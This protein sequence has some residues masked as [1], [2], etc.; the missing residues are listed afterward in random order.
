MSD[1]IYDF[2][3]HPQQQRGGLMVY[4]AAWRPFG[5][6]PP[7]DSAVQQVGNGFLSSLG[8]FLKP[9]AISGTKTVGKAIKTV[10]PVVGKKLMKIGMRI[11]KDY[12]NQR[13]LNDAIQANLR[14]PA[15]ETA[16]DYLSD[17]SSNVT[18]I[19]G[20]PPPPDRQ[21]GKDRKRKAILM[22]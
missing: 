10:A 11:L 1:S 6:S 13:N 18:P 8:S 20:L 5:S 9:L 14:Q 16:N 12:A 4:K 22:A 17:K 21:A 19:D 7:S 15:A 2:Y 3:S